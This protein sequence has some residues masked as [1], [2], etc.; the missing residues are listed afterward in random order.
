MKWQYR[1]VSIF[2]IFFLLSQNECSCVCVVFFTLISTSKNRTKSTNG[3]SNRVLVHN[4]Q[5]FISESI[6]LKS[7][8]S[9]LDARE[10]E[11]ER[12]LQHTSQ[13]TNERN[14]L[15]STNSY[16]KKCVCVYFFGRQRFHFH[17]FVDR[18]FFSSVLV[19]A[20]VRWLQCNVDLSMFVKHAYKSF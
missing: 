1:N 13:Q 6:K 7:T 2:G 19:C 17:I 15:H 8:E 10:R 16:S 4:I 14:L 11:R 5:R 20:V 18:V 12:E 3:N 9:E